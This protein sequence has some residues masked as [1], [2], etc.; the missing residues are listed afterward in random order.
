MPWL[1]L[2]IGR[3]AMRDDYRILDT[4]CHQMESPTLWQ[5][6]IDPAFR[7]R[8]PERVESDGRQTMMV[9]GGAAPKGC[10]ADFGSGARP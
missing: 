5:E 9:E 8:A 10:G 6:Y 3:I 2:S 1:A 7:D 4:D